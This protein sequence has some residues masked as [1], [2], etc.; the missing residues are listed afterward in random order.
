MEKQSQ[1]VILGYQLKVTGEGS[2]GEVVRYY[3]R[4]IYIQR[5]DAEAAIPEWITSLYEKT[6]EDGTPR[7]WFLTEHKP[8]DISII[9]VNI[10]DGV[11]QQGEN[12]E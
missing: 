7:L 9:P 10:I 8:E 12:S 5:E 3:S 6:F 4:N 2:I 1:R 11:V